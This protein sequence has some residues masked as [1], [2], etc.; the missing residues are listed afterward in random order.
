MNDSKK[1]IIDQFKTLLT[2]MQLEYANE[3]IIFPERAILLSKVNKEDLSA[4][5]EYS[6]S[7]AEIRK[8]QTVNTFFLDNLNVSEQIGMDK[9]GK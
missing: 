2:A 1:E 8:S 3:I 4:I 6:D 5:L 9:R 7:I